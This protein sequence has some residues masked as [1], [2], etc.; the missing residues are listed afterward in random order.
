VSA[1]ELIA[2]QSAASYREGSTIAAPGKQPVK[3]CSPKKLTRAVARGT[4]IY[5]NNNSGT[6]S[7]SKGTEI[8]DGYIQIFYIFGSLFKKT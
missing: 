3:G 7:M 1:D 6:L 2:H 8:M 4:L 5:I